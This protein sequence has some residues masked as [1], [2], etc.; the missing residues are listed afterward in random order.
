MNLPGNPLDG[1]LVVIGVLLMLL[2]FR[3]NLDVVIWS[4]HDGGSVTPCFILVPALHQFAAAR[5]L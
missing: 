4:L 2:W 5:G 3:D 1:T